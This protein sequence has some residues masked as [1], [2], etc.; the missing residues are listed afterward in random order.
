MK[1]FL[2]LSFFT[3]ISSIQMASSKVFR[4]SISENGAS[5]FDVNLLQEQVSNSPLAT[6]ATEAVNC[7]TASDVLKVLEKISKKEE[8]S[9]EI[10]VDR[11]SHEQI[12]RARFSFVYPPIEND[13]VYHKRYSLAKAKFYVKTKVVSHKVKE[14]ANTVKVKFEEF[15]EKTRNAFRKKKLAVQKPA[16]T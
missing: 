7:T 16:T 12:K 9:V 15:A 1:R 3:L 6:L 13:T 8:S 11:T 10:I 5:F 2:V 14:W 4:L